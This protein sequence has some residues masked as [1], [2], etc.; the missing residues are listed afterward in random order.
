M[1]R[2][3]SGES[4]IFFEFYS[5]RELVFETLDHSEKFLAKFITEPEAISAKVILRE[6]LM[7]AVIHGNKSNK[8]LSAKCAIEHLGGKRFKIWVEDEGL[9]FDYGSV[10]NDDHDFQ[11]RKRGRGYLLINRLS[12][13]I[14]FNKKGNRVTV[15]L[16]CKA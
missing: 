4:T 6:L 7:N 12:D 10:A 8:A 2:E 9:G 14:Q 16:K 5:Y 13:G 11:S 15:Y 1:Y 3:D